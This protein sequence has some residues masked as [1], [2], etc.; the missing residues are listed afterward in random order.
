LIRERIENSRD[1]ELVHM[2]RDGSEEWRAEVL[3]LVQ[4]E[5]E[6]RGVNIDRV[7]SELETAPT[8]E[9]PLKKD[10]PPEKR[11]GTGGWLG[12]LIGQL[13]SFSWIG[14]LFGMAYIPDSL[15]LGTWQAA[16]Y[17]YLF[18][19]GI[20]LWKE[21]PGAVLHTQRA[22]ISLAVLKGVIVVILLSAN[23]LTWQG[24][25]AAIVPLVWI[26]YLRKS[27]RVLNTYPS[28]A[29]HLKKAEEPVV[30]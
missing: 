2:I 23:F 24:V 15:L 28:W 12:L 19:C 17:A 7:A 26:A 30:P 5:L 8:G 6:K 18:F 16:T 13:V 22:L 11:R 21:K 27:H 9:W 4:T 20:A 29:L 3:A 10:T 25:G 1:E 14:V